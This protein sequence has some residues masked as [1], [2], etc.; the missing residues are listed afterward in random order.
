MRYQI[1]TPALKQPQFVCNLSHCHLRRRE[2]VKQVAHSRAKPVCVRVSGARHRVPECR[3]Q[4]LRHNIVIIPSRTC[5][6]LSPPLP[7]LRGRGT[8]R[9]RH[10]VSDLGSYRVDQSSRHSKRARF[11]RAKECAQRCPL[12]A[13]LCWGAATSCSVCASFDNMLVLYASYRLASNLNLISMPQP[14]DREHITELRVRL[15][16]APYDTALNTTPY[17]ASSSETESIIFN[18]GRER[19]AAVCARLV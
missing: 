6:S 11:D 10:R 19:T 4:H 13:C 16:P 7:A 15:I 9:T 5:L 8:A 12:H 18:V 2:R 3:R 1:L 14:D 17:S